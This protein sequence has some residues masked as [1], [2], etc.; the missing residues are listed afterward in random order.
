[1][2]SRSGARVSKDNDARS[3][4]EEGFA[5]KSFSLGSMTSAWPRPR[6]VKTEENPLLAMFW[7]IRVHPRIM[8]RYSLRPSLMYDDWNVS[9]KQ[10]ASIASASLAVL[11]ELDNAAFRLRMAARRCEIA[12]SERS[13]GEII[14]RWD[15]ETAKRACRR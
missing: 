2:P 11:G 3:T 15:A 5:G 1:M 6:D 8:V 4:T 7:A 9:A 13:V 12:D 10:A 14:V